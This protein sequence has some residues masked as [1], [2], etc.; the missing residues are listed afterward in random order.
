MDANGTGNSNERGKRDRNR[1]R[2][3]TEREGRETE[4]EWEREKEGERGREGERGIEGERGEREGE[5]RV[6]SPS[7][8]RASVRAM[9]TNAGSVRAF[10]A[11]LMRFTISS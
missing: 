8:A 5:R 11:A 10:T 6:F 2:G 1:E 3:E 9:M 7:T 4:R